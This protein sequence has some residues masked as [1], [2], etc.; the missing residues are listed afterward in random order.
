MQWSDIP[1]HAPARTLRQFAVLW[2]LFFG[3]WAAWQAWGR[4]RVGLGLA[5]AGLAIVVG[6]GGLVR[7]LRIR[8]LFVGW[9]VLAFPIGWTVSHVVLALVFH[10]LFT[11]L[12]VFFRLAGRDPLALRRKNGTSYWSERPETTDVRRYFRQY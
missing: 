8:P 1:F 12:G 2:L 4:G 5:L 6:L 10:G 7:P 9:M 11:P 3:G